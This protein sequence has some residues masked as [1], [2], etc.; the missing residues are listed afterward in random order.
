MT[1]DGSYCPLFEGFKLFVQVYPLV[2]IHGGCQLFLG[3]RVLKDLCLFVLE[4]IDKK[5]NL[6]YV[7]CDR[8]LG[9]IYEK[10]ATVN[11]H[12]EFSDYPQ[13]LKIFSESIF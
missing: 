3:I 10:V 12:S 13:E 7:G 2:P 1:K 9:Q 5:K 4:P 8:F 6:D 11:L